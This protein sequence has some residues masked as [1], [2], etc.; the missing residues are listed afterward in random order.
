MG[1]WSTIVQN[2]QRKRTKQYCMTTIVISTTASCSHWSKHLNAKLSQ[3]VRSR[4]KNA[5]CTRLCNMSVVSQCAIYSICTAVLCQQFIA[6]TE[7]KLM[8]Q[9]AMISDDPVISLDL[10]LTI[11]VPFEF[12]K[13]PLLSLVQRKLSREWGRWRWPANDSLWPLA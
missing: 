11:H 13:K 1:Q 12:E 3:R 9:C 7:N 8:C 4:H 2:L 6:C 10:L 5:H